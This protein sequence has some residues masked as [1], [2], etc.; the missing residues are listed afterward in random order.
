[1]KRFLLSVFACGVLFN[2]CLKVEEL[3]PEPIIKFERFAVQ[4]DSVAF[5]TFSFQDGDGDIGLRTGDTLGV[6]HRDSLYY[7]NLF[8]EY[9]E[10]DSGEWVKQDVSVP[11]YYRIPELSPI[12][13]NPTLEGDIEVEL[14]PFFNPFSSLDTFRFEAKMV[15]RSLNESNLIVTPGLVKSSF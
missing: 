8:L 4:G 11:F 13:Q 14:A 2:A 1:M 6:F 10:L 15:D 5:F 12:G 9:F 3:P 7:N